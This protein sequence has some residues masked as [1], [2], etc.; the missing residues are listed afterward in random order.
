M[1]R[2]VNLCGIDLHLNSISQQKYD[3][4]LKVLNLEVTIPS[5][6]N[7]KYKYK[8]IGQITLQ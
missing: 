4:L 7:K 8:D 6:V 3:I 2:N 5:Q 1:L